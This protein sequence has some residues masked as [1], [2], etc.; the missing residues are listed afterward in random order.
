MSVT[1]GYETYFELKIN[2]NFTEKSETVITAAPEAR[3]L[4]P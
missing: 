3:R 4:R 1:R 2:D